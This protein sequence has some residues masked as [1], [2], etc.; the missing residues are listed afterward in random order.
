MK[1]SNRTLALL[2]SLLIIGLLVWFFTD[3]VAYLCIAWVLSMIGQ[4]LMRFYKKHLHIGKFRA[5]K[6]L[7]AV[8]TL[9]TFFLVLGLLFV[10]FLPPIIEQVNNLAH[11][12]YRAIATALEKPMQEWQQ[13]L[14]AYGI[15]KGGVPL[16]EQLRSN[17]SQWFEP[18]F[19]GNYFGNLMSTVGDFG[20]GLASVLFISF[21][22]LE[23][24]GMFADFLSALLP[25]QYDEK[26]RHALADIADM[27][28]RYFRGLLLQLFI[29]ATLVTVGLML[30]GVKNALLIGF[31]AG[32][33]NVIPYVGPIIGAAFGM[34][35]TISS[36][37]DMDF[38][39]FILPMV[40][41]V[42]LVFVVAQVIDNNFSQPMIFSKSVQAHPL[43]IFIVVLMG[44]QVSG[45][46]GMV[47]AIPA[48]TVIRAI[49]KVFLSEFHIVQQLTE[50]LRDDGEPT[51]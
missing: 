7:S 51:S 20:V 16:E 13:K 15:V 46:M 47:L 30:L 17:F 50:R 10:I 38:Y 43:E 26:V 14:A 4:P 23:D 31:F 24:E 11:V 40:G 42:A 3:I 34:G 21:F 49:A 5:G 18:R 35:L 45:A 12:D 39:D 25:P 29:F 27:L 37:L 9:I 1:L 32:L 41:K 36:N 48:Y 28:S 8:L 2:G 33:L 19:I 6:G 22:F 44:A